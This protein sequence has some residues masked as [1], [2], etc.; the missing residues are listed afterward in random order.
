MTTGGDLMLVNLARATFGH[1][2]WTE[3]LLTG[4]Y[5]WKL[6]EGTKNGE[7]WGWQSRNA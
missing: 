5:A 6:G 7:E 2:G 1:A 3:R 4:R